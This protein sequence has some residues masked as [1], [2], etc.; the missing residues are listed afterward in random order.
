MG[1]LIGRGK[2][3]A[4]ESRN[5]ERLQ[6]AAGN[7]RGVYLLRLGE[8][9]DA[10]RPRSPDAERLERA[11]VRRKR[12]I[13]RGG[14]AQLA[15]KLREPGSTRRIEVERNKL[16]RFRIGQRPQQHTVEYAEDGRIGSNTD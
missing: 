1:V 5:I 9:R 15:A 4:G 14:E 11:V 7:L 13:H 12:E 10:R 3:L 16:C 6:N 2:P 8:P